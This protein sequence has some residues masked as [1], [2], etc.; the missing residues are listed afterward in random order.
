MRWQVVKRVG[1]APAGCK[2]GWIAG[3]AQLCS[4]LALS[5]EPLEKRVKRCQ[6]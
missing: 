3:R 1:P 2:M 4:Q 5:Q 6:L